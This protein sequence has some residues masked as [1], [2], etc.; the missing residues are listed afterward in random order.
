MGL[1]AQHMNLAETRNPE[2]DVNL[3]A[4][5]HVNTGSAHKI[6]VEN[7]VGVTGDVV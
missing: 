5:D 1:T 7:M 6:N 2:Q 3:G 4:V